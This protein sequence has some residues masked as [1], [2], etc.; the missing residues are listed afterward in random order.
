MLLEIILVLITKHG[1]KL[2]LKLLEP[3]ANFGLA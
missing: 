1:T 2:H 3:A